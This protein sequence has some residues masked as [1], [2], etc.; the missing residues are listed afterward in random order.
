VN[1]S[2]NALIDFMKSRGFTPCCQFCGQ[3]AETACY[4]SGGSYMHLCNE[5]AGRMR[6]DVTMATKKKDSKSE[7]VIGGIVGA[8][9]GS[10]L[11]VICI[12]VFGRMGRVAVASGIVMAVCTIKG[13]ELLGGKFTKKGVV[14][15]C[16]MM[17][18]M[19]F[20]GNNI[21]WAIDIAEFFEVD[22]FS[23]FRGVIPL[24]QEGYL[25]ASTYYYN[26]IL[27]YVF[28]AIGAVPTVIGSLKDS[29]EEG[30][31]AQIGSTHYM[32]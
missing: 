32:N 31:F 10:V 30:Q 7:N 12:V 21:D 17:I 9:L 13:Y 14:I 24:L 4:V 25:E 20:V 23:A 26:L 18:V 5:C 19:T 15:S 28:T 6:N 8:L 3:Q 27:L 2:I 29:K 16:L 11:G 22:F 1:I